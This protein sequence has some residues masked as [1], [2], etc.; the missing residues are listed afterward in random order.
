MDRNPQVIY[1]GNP[2]SQQSAR[3]LWLSEKIKIESS[4]IIHS[5][6]KKQHCHGYRK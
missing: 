1:K 3:F 6:R 2:F 5:K 4:R